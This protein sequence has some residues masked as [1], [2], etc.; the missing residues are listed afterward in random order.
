MFKIEKN[1]ENIGKHLANL[2]EQ[3]FQSRRAFCKA[4]ILSAGESPNEETISN[5]SNR[6]SQIIK[7]K[8]AIQT[9]DLPYF[10][11]LL[12]VSSE[13]ILS[14]GKYNAQ[15]SNR[16][17][18]YSIACSKNPLE[19]KNYIERKDKLIL[20]CDEYCKTVIDYALEFRNYDFLKFLMDNGY[21]WFDSGNDK[22]YI[23]TFGAGTSIKRR[24][25]GFID[26]GLQYALHERDALRIN[27]ITLAADNN[28]IEM[29]NNLRARENPQ[30][31]FRA[32]YISGQHPNF[33]SCC[34]E[35]MVRHIA[36]SSEKILDYFTDSFQIRDEIRYN[37]GSKRVHTFM[38]PYISKLLDLLISTKSD[39]TETA[40]K[41]A[42][43]YNEG[44]YQ[45]L[46]ELILLVKN[47]ERYAAEYTRDLWIEEIKRDID[48]YDNGDIIMLRA[49]YAT[50]VNK[51]Q[52]GGIITNVPH[53]TKV[54]VS[55]K[56]KLLSEKLNE[57]YEK[58]RTI[59][60]H[61]EE[62]E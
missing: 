22:D 21:I 29:L 57:T 60:G 5:M 32:H 2:I 12:G 45:K 28:D 51:Y 55:P 39:Y 25:T 1:N 58:I 14:A 62:I 23:Q 24:E 13:H 47:D 54:S 3:K 37:D 4:Y 9:Y 15:I 27:L 52:V 50:A 40:L 17:T 6:L 48:F 59:S 7:G 41:K 19:W 61:I 44:T 26:C 10:T 31:Y 16:V 33:N 38:F 18:N 46:C 34:N 56:I 35:R 20:N 42:I 43:K 30:L 36:S 8:K 53:V 49:F 11:E